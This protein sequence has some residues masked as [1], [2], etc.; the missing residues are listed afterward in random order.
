MQRPAGITVLAFAMFTIG[1]IALVISFFCFATGPV[2]E[3]F[4][5][6]PG[7]PIYRILGAAVVGIIAL[8]LGLL[9]IVA[10]AGLW[11]MQAWGRSLAI[12]LVVISVAVSILGVAAGLVFLR[13]MI[14]ILRII[15]L[16]VDS[17]IL[18]YLFQPH[19]RNAF[20]GG[21]TRA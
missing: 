16:G 12:V 4:F 5:R 1:A 2:V 20:E 18:W 10:G 15:A 8:I 7:M 11:K 9:C 17:L 19:V 6:I 13:M 3:D 21:A 14:A